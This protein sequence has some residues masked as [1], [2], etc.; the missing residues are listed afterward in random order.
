MVFE[1]IMFCWIRF[2]CFGVSEGGGEWLSSNSYND[3]LGLDSFQ[4]ITYTKNELLTC[5]LNPGLEADAYKN[6]GFKSDFRPILLV[7][8]KHS[9]T[10]SY[11][12]INTFQ[13]LKT[14]PTGP[15]P[16]EIIVT[17]DQKFAYFSSYIPPGNTISVVDLMRQKMIKEIHTGE[18]TRIH[19]AAMAPDGKMAY[20]TAGQTG[21]V[22]EVNT[23]TNEVT[24]AIPTEGKISHMVYVSP[25]GKY[26]YTGNIS[27]A[28]VSV[29][30]RK[31][32][33][34]IKKIPTGKGAGG[35]TF[36]PDENQLWVTNE[37]DETISIIDLTSN[38]VI[39]TFSCPGIIKRIAFTPDKKL[40]LV[41]SWTKKGEVI[42][43]DPI[44]KKEIKRI[45]VGDNAIG[46]AFSPDGNYAFV[47]CEDA[48]DVYDTPGED[49]SLTVKA[50]QSDG[51]HV[52]DMESLEVIK[53]IK[54]GFGPDPMAIWYP[55]SNWKTGN[56]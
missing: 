8:N 2:I 55:P 42:V 45:A 56:E 54:T 43:L 25:D 49:E 35:M 4:A 18:Y 39:E 40:V 21:Y 48:R 33:E 3:E 5:H 51:V 34:L 20:F 6:S 46:L 13:I 14:I 27:S 41:S 9:N 24:R 26:L 36:S 47:G 11:V 12:D 15:N 29:I 22:I 53:I 23:K 28:D 16:H 52:I 7:A 50:D 30:D 1:I 31:S 37:T 32:G 19:G 17:P 38:L 44:T 10:L